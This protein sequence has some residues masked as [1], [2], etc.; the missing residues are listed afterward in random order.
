[1]KKNGLEPCGWI[2]II[3]E[4]P[5]VHLRHCQDRCVSI[6]KKHDTAPLTAP[7]SLEMLKHLGYSHRPKPG[8]F[9]HN[10]LLPT[11]RLRTASLS[12]VALSV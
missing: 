8:G 6:F 3:E 11:P 12:S 5:T 10:E 1:M 4:E 7:A 9:E 2:K